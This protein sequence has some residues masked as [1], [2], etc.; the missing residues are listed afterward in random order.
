[1]GIYL[2]VYNFQPDEKTQ[3]PSGEIFYEIDKVDSTEKLY[4]FTE[5]SRRSRTPRRTR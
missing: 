4:E 5:D 2:Q 3:K 1:M